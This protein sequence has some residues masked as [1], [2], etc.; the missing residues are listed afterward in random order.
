MK[1]MTRIKEHTLIFG[2]QDGVQEGSLRSS[3]IGGD[4]ALPRR[5]LHAMHDAIRR[6]GHAR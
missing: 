6:R 2:A 1:V 5:F 4:P 3:P